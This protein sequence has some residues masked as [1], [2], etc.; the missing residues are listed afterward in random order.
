MLFG[1]DFLNQDGR[2]A[3]AVH[4]GDGKSPTAVID[5]FL[6]LRDVPHLKKQEAGQGFKARFPGQHNVVAVFE[7]ADGGSALKLQHLLLVGRGGADGVVLVANIAED[8]LEHI[9]QGD[10]SGDGSKFVDDQG[11]V[12]VIGAKLINQLIERLG[13]WHDQGFADEAAEAERAGCTAA[14]VR[15]AAFIP[16]ADEVLVMNDADDLFGAVLINGQARKFVFRHDAEHVLEFGVDGQRNDAMARRHDLTRGVAGELD[17]ALNSVLFEL[18]QVTFVTAGL[19]DKLELFGCVAAVRMPGAEPEGA[20]DQSRGALDH[21]D[22]GLRKAIKE[23]QHRRGEHGNAIG[24]LERQVL[25]H[26]FADDDVRVADEQECAREGDAVQQDGRGVE[27]K[28]GEQAGEQAIDGIFAGPAETKT[29]ERDADLGDREEPSRI[30]E[31][32]QGVLSARVALLGELAQARLPHG[33]EGD[34]RGSE[35]AV[36]REDTCQRYE[37]KTHQELRWGPGGQTGTAE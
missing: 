2:D 31:E 27:V 16:N 6:E 32:A 19:N 17:E 8:L 18:L 28:G 1:L 35:K 25:G 4:L 26:D 21:D 22:E 7:V 12:G 23:Q 14:I 29:C 10:E 33:N 37:A 3:I 13:F 15:E 20:E 11:H 24:L 9:F 34:L 5:R 36:R 30:R